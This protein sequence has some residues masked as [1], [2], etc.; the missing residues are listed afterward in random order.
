MW[1]YFIVTIVIPVGS[2]VLEKSILHSD[3]SPLETFPVKEYRPDIPINRK[4]N[5]ICFFFLYTVDIS[6]FGSR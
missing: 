1:R 5:V 2:S 6:V 4:K 3:Y